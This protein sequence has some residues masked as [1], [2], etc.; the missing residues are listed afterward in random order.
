MGI[1]WKFGCGGLLSRIK[2]NVICRKSW[3]CKSINVSLQLCKPD[4]AAVEYAIGF[5]APLFLILVQKVRSG[6][7]AHRVHWA[8]MCRN[9]GEDGAASTSPLPNRSTVKGIYT[10]YR[11]WKKKIIVSRIECERKIFQATTPENR[12]ERDA[13]MERY[14]PEHIH[15]LKVCEL[16]VS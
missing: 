5:S 16:P 9:S 8:Y 2:N 15:S 11:H 10:F 12:R 4:Y 6:T 13:V 1:R 7:R 3:Q 14:T